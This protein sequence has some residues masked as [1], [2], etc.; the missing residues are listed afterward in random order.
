MSHR[1]ALVFIPALL[2]ACAPEPIDPG[3]G[4]FVQDI[5]IDGIEEGAH[6][7]ESHDL[8]MCVNAD[9][10]VF[11]VWVDDRDGVEAVW[12]NRS[13]DNGATW[14]ANPLR[15]NR[16]NAPVEGPQIACQDDN[17]YVVW[18]DKRDG[19]TQK[20]QIYFNRSN[21]GGEDWLATDMLLEDDK[22][23]YTDSRTPVIAAHGPWVHVAWSDDAFGAADIFVAS[24]ENFGQHWRISKSIDV[25]PNE[26]RGEAASTTPT[27]AASLNG[28]VHVAW[29]DSRNGGGDIYYNRSQNG[30]MSWRVATKLDVGDPISHD[31]EPT[32]NSMHP[33]IAADGPF[34]YVA[35]ADDRN[36][37]GKDI[38]VNFSGDGGDKWLAE[39]IRLETD[40]PGFFN[41]IRPR[42]VSQKGK[43]HIVWQDNRF[44]GYDIYYRTL[45][46]GKLVGD[47]E[48][49]IDSGDPEGHNNS[50]NPVIAIGKDGRVVVAWEDYR[51]EAALGLDNGYTDLYY[52]YDKGDGFHEDRDLRIDAMEPGQSWKT[53]QQLA[54]YGGWLF[55]SWVDG[56]NGSGDIYFRALEI[57]TETVV[58]SGVATVRSVE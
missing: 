14:F 57:G 13:I 15:I 7:P 41:S 6:D 39:D 38:Y 53:E 4:D 58:E 9:G 1:A 19:E 33:T 28:A 48:T 22:D 11:A 43:A 42:M 55:T 5:R 26:A 20:R 36:G 46:N 47:E 56:R 18:V 17:I 3:D 30:G 44:E 37:I 32:T 35:W 16:S 50:E 21:N 31:G 51:G 29:V 34:V 23:G 49:R 45:E 54:V 40:N 8:Q 2:V 25:A 10:H 12:F 52:N 27:I 24:S